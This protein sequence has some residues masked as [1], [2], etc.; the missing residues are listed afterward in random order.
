MQFPVSQSK[1]GCHCIQLSTTPCTVHQ[2]HR[3]VGKNKNLILSNSFTRVVKSHFSHL[4]L[5]PRTFTSVLAAVLY[6]LQ[7]LDYIDTA[8]SLLTRPLIV[9]DHSA[10]I[11]SQC[12]VSTALYVIALSA[13]C[14]TSLQCDEKLCTHT[15]I[16]ELL[17]RGAH[18]TLTLRP[19]PGYAIVVSQINLQ[20]MFN[21]INW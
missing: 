8:L 19:G 5:Q 2:I 17:Q 18:C 12:A 20:H 6:L 13:L 15:H 10:V 14:N 4:M 3:R 21:C 7:I 11:W 16:T 9:N 1:C